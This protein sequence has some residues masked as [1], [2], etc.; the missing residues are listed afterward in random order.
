MQSLF[1]TP[2]FIALH[3]IRACGPDACRLLIGP[4]AG[5]FGGFSHAAPLEVMEAVLALAPQE[6][7]VKLAPASHD[8][9]LFS[10]SMNALHRAGFMLAYADLNYERKPGLLDFAAGISDGARKKL[11]KCE[12][13][14]YSSMLL[15]DLNLQRAAHRLLEANRERMGVRLSLSWEAL[16]ALERALP[17]TYSFFGTF[18]GDAMI[19]A[20]ICARVREDVL[21]VYAWG[22]A[23]KNEYAPTVHLARTIYEEACYGG[24]RLLDAGIS[25]VQGVPNAGLIR[26]K[27]SLGFT[28]SVKATMV[29]K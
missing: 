13:A 29:R 26:F 5:T 7:E 12:R 20:A 17:D 27:E 25:T 3:G 18:D 9:A 1:H 16:A 24:Y 23:Q 6:C 19:A 28:P 2:E 21:Y 10:R 14:G 8:M 22:D 4:H 15:S 11:A